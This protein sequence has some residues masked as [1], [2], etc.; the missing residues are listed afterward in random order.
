MDSIEENE[1]IVEIYIGSL[2]TCIQAKIKAMV[3]QRIRNNEGGTYTLSGWNNEAKAVESRLMEGR[4]M[5]NPSSKFWGE[6]TFPY[7]FSKI[8]S[9][10]LLL[11]YSERKG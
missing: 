8:I 1:K 10:L 4:A 5:L 2:T 3:V 6:P 7:T 9:R 11:N